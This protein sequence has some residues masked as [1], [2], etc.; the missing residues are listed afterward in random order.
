MIALIYLLF[1]SGHDA[2]LVIGR[3]ALIVGVQ[4]TVVLLACLSIAMGGGGREDPG[5]DDD[6]RG[7]PRPQPPRTPTEPHV[8]WPDFERQFAEHVDALRAGDKIASS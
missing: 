5:S 7:P 4:A 8:S 3:V 1:A 6:G 2:A